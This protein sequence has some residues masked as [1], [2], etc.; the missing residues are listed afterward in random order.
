LRESRSI[1]DRTDFASFALKLVLSLSSWS[2]RS[3]LLV[4]LILILGTQASGLP[5]VE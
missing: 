1:N 3:G 2:S 5:D 4:K